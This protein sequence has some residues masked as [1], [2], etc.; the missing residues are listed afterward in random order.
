MKQ[1]EQPA[2]QSVFI[3]RYASYQSRVE[4]ALPAFVGTGKEEA[5]GTAAEAAFY[6]L[7]AG[8]KRIRPVLLMATAEMLGRQ[9]NDLLPF[10]CAL[11]MIHTYSL[12]H[13]DLP[14]M[15]DDDLRRG[16]PTC[17][18]VY[19]EAIAVL[20]GDYLLNK[21]YET[22]LA[23]INLKR[24]ASLEAA[25][26]I[27]RAAGGHGMIGGQVLDLA[28]EKRQLKADEL[29]SLHLKKTGALIVAPVEAAAVLAGALPTVRQTLVRYAQAIGL[30]FQIRD[31]ILDV[32]AS[33][34]ELGK[35]T[36][37]DERDGKSTYVSLFGLEQA[38]KLLESTSRT[39]LEQLEQLDETLDKSFLM[40]LT[41]YLLTR[42]K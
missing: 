26:L 22:L 35:S 27:A 30:A 40:A 33:Q 16:R 23:A 11:E 17:H 24:P 14:C 19:G 39:A 32:T 6:S 31:D 8:G 38:E 34:P 28:A 5:G 15:D 18:I 21:A 37:K 13:D 7:L 2:G 36:G 9:S 12:I 4:Q 29:Q 25:R 10:A 42:G 41:A 3:K 20:A 1:T